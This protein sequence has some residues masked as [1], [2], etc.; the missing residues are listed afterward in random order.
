MEYYNAVGINLIQR[1]SRK[2]VSEVKKFEK[3]KIQEE[4]YSSDEF[5]D[6]KSNNSRK[7]SNKEIYKRKNKKSNQFFSNDDMEEITKKKKIL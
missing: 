3:N 4:I 1:N 6:V 5:I 2:G 7:N